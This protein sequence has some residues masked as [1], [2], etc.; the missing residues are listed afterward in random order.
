MT[1]WAAM[2]TSAPPAVQQGEVRG[3]QEGQK[4]EMYDEMTLSALSTHRKG[5]L[6]CTLCM[7]LVFKDSRGNCMWMKYLHLFLLGRSFDPSK[8]FSRTVNG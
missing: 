2:G 1:L 4:N 5:M 6:T 7:D 3:P 8:L